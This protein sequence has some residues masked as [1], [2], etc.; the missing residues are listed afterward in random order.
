MNTLDK[1]KGSL[2]FSAIGDSL[3]WITEFTND[4]AELNKRHGVETISDF[5]TWEKRVGGRFYGYIDTV[6]SGSYSDDTQLMLSVA[7]SL[8]LDKNV[9]QEYFAETELSNWLSYSRGAGRTI[10]NAAR[11]IQRKTAKW[12]DNYFTFNIG[13]RKIDYRDSGANGAA[14]RIL[15]IA[16]VNIND[17]EN[18]LKNVAS[19][20]I[21]T[22]GHPTAII[23]ALLY[24][25]S[26]HVNSKFNISNFDSKEYL[27]I[28]GHQYKKLVSS[29][30]MERNELNYWTNKWDAGWGTKF[31]DLFDQSFTLCLDGLRNVYKSINADTSDYDML[32]SLGCFKN[33]TKGSGIG[34][35][36][37]G[38]YLYCRYPK[39]PLIG[40]N[41]AVNSFGADTDSIAAFYGGL[42]GYLHGMDI[43]KPKHKMLQDYHYIEQVADNLFQISNDNFSNQLNAATKGDLND[44]KEDNFEINQTVTFKPLG[45][46]IIENIDRQDTLTSGKY[47]L[48]LKVQ[49]DIGQS[50]IFSKILN[51]P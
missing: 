50:C 47:N 40:M 21:V 42:M 33:S 49:F 35:V 12:N 7:R 6:A 41:S 1:Y 39:D 5:L 32:A 13:K 14:M 17:V 51:S 23:G 26:I 46:G 16:L 22:H 38:I 15:P 19:N 27:T 29:S 28:L 34:T 24:A 3:G 10:K 25:L 36:L 45:S 4:K 11:K 9:D 30:L 44:I 31:K 20:S 43:I 18:A 48:I 2:L 8:R 37:A